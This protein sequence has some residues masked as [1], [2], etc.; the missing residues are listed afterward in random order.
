MRV[1]SIVLS[2]VV[3]AL[4]ASAAAQGDEKPKIVKEQVRGS[5][6]FPAEQTRI[7]GKV[8][9][10]NA[11]TLLFEDGTEVDLRMTMDAPDLEQKGL[12]G[13]SFYPAGQEA[14]EFLRKL[15]G[16]RAVTFF[17]GSGAPKIEGQR[18]LRGLCFV[19]E[20]SLQIEM[21][22][23]G[24]AFSQHSATEPY[25]IF[26]RENKRGLW[27]GKFVASER[28][29][30]GERLLGETVA[31]QDDKPGG[32]PAQEPKGAEQKRDEATRPH[33]TTSLLSSLV[34]TEEAALKRGEWGE[35]RRYFRGETHGTK[36]RIVLSVT[37]KPGQAPHPPHRHAEEEFM[38]IAEGTGSWHLDGKE[39]AART[40]D[41]VYAAPWTMH[42]LKSTGD[43]PLTYYM[44]K[45]NNTAVP[46]PQPPVER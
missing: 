46:A 8:K 5:I 6:Q 27:R 19:G 38:I 10:V 28:W 3:L 35:W 33:P 7:T 1:S 43:A 25:E 32:K 14:A 20:T 2:V 24:W 36:D 18:G 22:R 29:R 42:G 44:V 26:A 4:Y 34:R 16:S 15:I 17:W 37:L 41:V 45:W 30:K 9:V 12:I 31:P 21:V 39:F 23:N 40:G 13:D 11:Y